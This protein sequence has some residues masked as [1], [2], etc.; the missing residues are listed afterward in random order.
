MLEMAN[1]IMRNISRS[2]SVAL[3]FNH[4]EQH[5]HSHPIGKHS[6]NLCRPVLFDQ[7]QDFCALETRVSVLCIVRLNLWEQQSLL[8]ME[9]G[10]LDELK[11]S[12]GCTSLSRVCLRYLVSPELL[13]LTQLLSLPRRGSGPS[14]VELA[15]PSCKSLEAVA[16]DIRRV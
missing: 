8:L 5:M 9:K 12:S 7:C 6:S 14:F 2:P 13:L 4:C 1:Q 16:L 3:W 11:A 15:L 10:E